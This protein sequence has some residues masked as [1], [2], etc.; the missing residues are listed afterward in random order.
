MTGWE[1]EFLSGAVG[2][3][4]GVSLTVLASQRDRER[5]A[6]EPAPRPVTDDR[7]VSYFSQSAI[8][9]RAIKNKIGGT[10]SSGHTVQEALRLI[11]RLRQETVTELAISLLDA[12][13]LWVENP[14]LDG[15]ELRK[16]LLGRYPVGE[17]GGI[18][19][20]FS[21]VGADGSVT[22][23]PRY[24]VSCDVCQKRS[25]EATS[26]A[27]ANNYAVDLGWRVSDAG[28]LCPSHQ[29]VESAEKAP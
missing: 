19:Q 3:G 22:A 9:F 17:D 16:M 25:P 5:S 20:K 4:F 15:V 18:D 27:L 13:V 11:D 1:W 12:C 10:D 7:T 29:Q 28:D 8:S 14:G 2:F 6:G 26:Q 23:T 21:V 24:S